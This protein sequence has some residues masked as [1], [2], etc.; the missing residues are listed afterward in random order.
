[1]MNEFQM[2][3]D[4]CRDAARIR[5]AVTARAV[6]AWE[7]REDIEQELLIAAWRRLSQYDRRKASLKT[8]LSRVMENRQRDI[9]RR[10]RAKKNRMLR[11][12]LRM[13]VL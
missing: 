4:E 6:G 11:Q 2:L 8:W 5:S 10:Y 12:A 3:D 13:E 1:M 9:I 7:D